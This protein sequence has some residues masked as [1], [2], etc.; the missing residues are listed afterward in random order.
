MRSAFA[1]QAEAALN[2]VTADLEGAKADRI[3]AYARLS[4]L[5]GVEE[6]FTG[7]SESLL[8]VPV[9]APTYGPVDPMTSSSFLAAQAERE[10]AERRLTADQKRAIPDVTAIVGVRR[11]AYE[12]STALT[13]IGRAPCRER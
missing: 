4:A 1:L 7:L 13:E 6:T 8:A 11:L 10:A 2:A 9:A 12:N 3:A 5:A